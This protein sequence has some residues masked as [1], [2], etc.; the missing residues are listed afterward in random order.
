MEEEYAFLKLL[1][2]EPLFLAPPDALSP[3]ASPLAFSFKG[4]YNRQILILLADTA[5][6]EEEILLFKILQAVKLQEADV[7]IVSL[8]HPDAVALADVIA[9]FSPQKI[10]AFGLA[11]AVWAGTF[12]TPSTYQTIPSL[13]ADNLAAI[14]QSTEK[15]KQLWDA[16]KVFFQ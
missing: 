13:L 2:T 10:L 5:S 4:G 7:A 8:N 3:G 14:S 15:K 1:L 12:Y 11:Q 6:A 9:H 16:M